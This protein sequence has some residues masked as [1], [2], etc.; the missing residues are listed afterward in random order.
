MKTKYIQPFY[1]ALNLKYACIIDV[2]RP[3]HIVYETDML[4]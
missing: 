3:Q 4:I 2:S 1:F